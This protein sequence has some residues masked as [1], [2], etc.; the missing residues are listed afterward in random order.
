MEI[1]YADAKPMYGYL[2]HAVPVDQPEWLHQVTPVMMT[3]YRRALCGVGSGGMRIPLDEKGNPRPW[4]G[5]DG[6]DRCHAKMYK[7]KAGK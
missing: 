4:R 5:I 7:L 6:C 3:T 1:K 2:T